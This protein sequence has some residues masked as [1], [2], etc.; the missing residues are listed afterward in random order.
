MSKF[1]SVMTLVAATL[2]GAAHAAPIMN[3]GNGHW[4][5]VVGP[6]DWVTAEAAAQAIAP[7]AHLATVNDAAEQA[8]LAANFSGRHWIGYNDIAVEGTFVWTSGETPGFTAW[9]AGEPNNAGNEDGTVL[10]WGGGG[11]W[12]DW[13][14]ANV[15]PGIAEWVRAPGPVPAPAA[16]GL[17][18]FG[19]AGLGMAMRRRMTR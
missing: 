14:V 15:I 10:N 2:A 19:L 5:D 17:L 1:L 11:C 7:G 12:N 4:Y 8:W 9:C 3:P 18:G 16:L 13:N 6:A